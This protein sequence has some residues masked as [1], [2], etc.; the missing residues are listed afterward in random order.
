MT[1]LSTNAIYD[2]V[3]CLEREANF[4]R[5]I[6]G[7]SNYERARDLVRI[8]RDAQAELRKLSDAM[9]RLRELKDAAD[10]EYDRYVTRQR[11]E[12]FDGCSCHINPPCGFCT[13]ETDEEA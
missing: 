11:C 10:R 12:E 8:S 2:A 3:Q 4:R 1:Y 5:N 13:R 6:G 9:P 7:N